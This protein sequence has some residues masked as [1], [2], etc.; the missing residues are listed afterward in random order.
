VIRAS[1]SSIRALHAGRS[2]DAASLLA[3][4]RASLA[5]AVAAVS[6]HPAV[7]HAGFVH[8]AAKELVEA[9][10]LAAMLA[11]DPVPAPSALGVEPAARLNG[12]AEAASELRRNLLDRLREGSFDRA[13]SLLREMET[14]YDAL[15]VVDLPDALSGGLRRTVDALRAVLERSRGDVTTT[16]LQERLRRAIEGGTHGDPS[17]H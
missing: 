17:V 2:D 3:D 11:G 9:S 13:E 4:A 12:V 6:P 16:V 15:V 7:Y 8:D 5:E 10:V 1:G 14:A